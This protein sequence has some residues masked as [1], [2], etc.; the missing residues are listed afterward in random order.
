MYKDLDGTSILLIKERFLFT[1]VNLIAARQGKSRLH[2]GLVVNDSESDSERFVVLLIIPLNN[3]LS[4][5]RH[6]TVRKLG[7]RQTARVKRS[8]NSVRVSITHTL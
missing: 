6:N 1:P 8:G 2:S 5:H 4:N 3:Q 7:Y